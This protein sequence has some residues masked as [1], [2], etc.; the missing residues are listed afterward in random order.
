MAVER[1]VRAAVAR[2]SEYVDTADAMYFGHSQGA[3]IAPGALA[4]TG[5]HFR[6]ALFFEGLPHEA[7]AAKTQLLRAGVERFLLVSGQGGWSSG[8]EH[9]AKSFRGTP[10]AAKHVHGDSGHFFNDEVFAVMRRE[11]PW[12]VDGAIAWQSEESAPPPVTTAAPRDIT[13]SRLR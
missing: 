8:H 9:L 10:L 7:A 6:Y 5:L 12:L 2:F 4:K 11:L 13:G 1:A 3:M